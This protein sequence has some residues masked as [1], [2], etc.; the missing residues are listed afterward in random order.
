M[1]VDPNIGNQNEQDA[2]ET[3]IEGIIKDTLEFWESDASFNQKEKFLWLKV[4][5]IFKD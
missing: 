1:E 4:A 5:T 2:L 3:M